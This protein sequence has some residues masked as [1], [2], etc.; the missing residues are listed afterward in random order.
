[1]CVNIAG[2]TLYKCLNRICA[3]F[4]AGFL[5]LG[6]HWIASHL[7]N[8]FEPYIMGISLFILG[9]FKKTY[10]EYLFIKKAYILSFTNQL[11][12]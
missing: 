7:G 11:F 3:T 6:I 2:G 9:N 1:M 10:H 12:S 5:A 8:Q 4:L